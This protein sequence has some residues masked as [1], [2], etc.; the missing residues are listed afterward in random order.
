MEKQMLEKLGYQVTACASSSEA[1]TVFSA[2]PDQFDLMI[3]DMTMP[4][5]A[6]DR[7]TEKV[8]GLRP[9]LPVILCTGYSDMINEDKAAALGIR[10]FVMKPVEKNELAGNPRHFIPRPERVTRPAPDKPPRDH[11][12]TIHW[13]RIAQRRLRSSPASFGQVFIYFPFSLSLVKS[14]PKA[15]THGQTHPS[16]CRVLHGPC[17]FRAGSKN[18]REHCDLPPPEIFRRR[19][20]GRR[21]HAHDRR[22]TG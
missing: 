22:G 7:L 16:F 6:G 20:D 4:H 21:H 19:P 10:R 5:M 8:L 12:L 15:W 3:T 14:I 2:R 13:A 11:A 9:N 1:W 17:R 18:R